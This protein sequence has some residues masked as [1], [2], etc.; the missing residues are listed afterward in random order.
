MCCFCSWPGLPPMCPVHVIHVMNEPRHSSFFTATLPLVLLL[1]TQTEGKTGE[2]QNKARTLLY[3]LEMIE[4]WG[5][6]E[7]GGGGGLNLWDQIC[8]HTLSEQYNVMLVHVQIKEVQYSQTS[9]DCIS[10]FLICF[11]PARV[12]LRAIGRNQVM[13]ILD[14][15]Y[16]R[17]ATTVSWFSVFDRSTMYQP[18]ACACLHG[19]VIVSSSGSSDLTVA[20]RYIS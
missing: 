9:H 13:C 16:A 14:G 17:R 18:T 11:A 19:T 3:T 4:S 7:R 6:L 20:E 8:M 10:N 12:Q 2:V 5:G 1:W 15:V